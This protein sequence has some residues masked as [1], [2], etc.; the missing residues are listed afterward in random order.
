MADTISSESDIVLFEK[1]A[2]PAFNG[3]AKKNWFDQLV[4][5][6]VK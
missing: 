6:S 4:F 5:I 1:D 3:G 2:W